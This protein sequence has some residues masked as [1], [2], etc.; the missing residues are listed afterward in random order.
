M[1]RLC[2]LSLCLLLIPVSSIAVE[3]DFIHLRS[4]ANPDSDFVDEP[5]RFGARFANFNENL[6]ITSSFEDG[7]FPD[8]G[9]VYLFNRDMGTQIRFY[10]NPTGLE[11]DQFG[12]SVVQVGPTAFA[13]SA[14]GSDFLAT[15]AG[16]VYIIHSETTQVLDTI[17][18]P[19]PTA[20]GA[21]GIWLDVIDGMLLVG[22]SG[23]QVDGVAAGA[24]YLVD[25]N[26]GQV[27]ST[28]KKPD[29]ITGDRFG[30]RVATFDNNHFIASADFDNT[31]ASDAGIAYLFQIG[32]ASPVQTYVNPS[33]NAGDRFGLYI[34]EVAGRVLVGAQLD[35]T[36]GT[37]SGQAYVFDAFAGTLIQTLKSPAPRSGGQF[38]VVSS[39]NRFAL[40]GAPFDARYSTQSGLRVTGAAYL[41]EPET[42]LLV[43]TLLSPTP[44]EDD[45]FGHRLAQVDTR[46]VGVSAFFSDIPSTNAGEVYLFE[47]GETTSSVGNFWLYE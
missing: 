24:V 15:D 38:G 46:T 16:V 34:T 22:A 30:I 44:S 6:L 35:D 45:N 39:F 9:K 4:I 20:G 32:D 31:G 11:D 8:T 37:N 10:N 1:P 18:S 13:V 40:I 7:A 27:V 43:G 47:V 3:L 33:P 42:G 29:P 26:D 19:N 21:F 12:T 36:N 23:D 17:Y 28:F 2:A 25:P 5:D 14:P 41:I